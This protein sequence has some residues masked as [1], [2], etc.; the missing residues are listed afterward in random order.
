MIIIGSLCLVGVSAL[1]MIGSLS[2]LYVC[3]TQGGVVVLQG[4]VVRHPAACLAI[5][6]VLGDVHHLPGP[7]WGLLEV[8]WSSWIFLVP[9]GSSSLVIVRKMTCPTGRWLSPSAS[10][11]EQHVS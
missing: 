7:L 3:L 5:L 11:L 4:Q 2:A 6:K 8:I 1:G 9:P 10:L